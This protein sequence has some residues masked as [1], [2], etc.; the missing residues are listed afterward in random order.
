[1]ELPRPTSASVFILISTPNSDFYQLDFITTRGYFALYIQLEFH[2]HELGLAIEIFD[3][4]TRP[5]LDHRPT[6]LFNF[7][8]NPLLPTITAYNRQPVLRLITAMMISIA[9]H[10]LIKPN[11]R[12]LFLMPKLTE[13]LGMRLF[14][15]RLK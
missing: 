12:L 4:L 6:T 2:S 9:K 13:I 7:S 3:L 1:M 14:L 15:P 11:T 8:T 5:N 10:Q